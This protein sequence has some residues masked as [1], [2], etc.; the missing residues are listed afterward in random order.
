VGFLGRFD[1]LEATLFG[2][3]GG[4]YIGGGWGRTGGA[5]GGVEF[6]LMD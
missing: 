6:V 4:C 5:G 2:E 3:A 1:G